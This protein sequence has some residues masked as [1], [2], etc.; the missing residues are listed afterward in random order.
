V[1]DWEEYV[2]RRLSI[3]SLP[4]EREMRIVR[5]LGAQLED[6]YREALAR[7]ASDS[8]AEAQ[9]E[10]QILDWDRL[11]LDLWR[12][13]R[14]R[15]ANP[16][17]RWSRKLEERAR[18]ARVGGSMLADLVADTRFAIR[19]LAKNPGFAAVA[20]VTLAIGIGA[21]SA[22][23]SVI[24]GVLL[25]P[26][27][28][29]SPERLVRVHET[30][31]QYGRFSVAP[32][33]FLDWRRESQA[34]ERIAAFSAGSGTLVDG[35]LVERVSS[36]EVSFD[37]FD[38]LGIA[39]LLGRG[40]SPEEDAPGRNGVVVV[41]HGAWQRH[42]GSD[43]GVLGRRVTLDGTAVTV[44]GVMPPDF[45]FPSR[46]NELWSPIALDPANAPR[47]A[48]YLGVIARL[49]PDA[50]VASARAEMETIA[51]RLADQFPVNAGES[52]EVTPLHEYIVGGSRASL[53]TLLTAVVLVT[54]I[55]CG[56][57]ANLL[58]GRAS[59]R[60]RE[61]ALRAALGAGRGRLARQMLAE[62]A[63]LALGGGAL[64]L[65]FAYA[66]LDPL[67][68]LSA[69]TIPRVEEIALDGGVLA[70][71]LGLS[72]VT[73]LGFALAPAW[74]SSRARPV[75]ALR[76][77]SR[78]SLSPGSRRARSALVAVEVALSLVL[79]VG[80]SLL[81]RSFRGLASVD[82][83][84][85]PENVLTL[86][87][88]LPPGDYPED[89]HLVHFYDQLLERL[90]SLPRVEAAGMVQSLPIEGDYFLSFTIEGRPDPPPGEEPSAN[91]R[92][93]SYGYFETVGVPIARGRTFDS[94]DGTRTPPVAVVDEAFVRRH[95]G[96]ED[97]LGR[98]IDVGNGSD[99]VYEIVGVAGDVRNDGLELAP[100]P[101]IYLPYPQDPFRT[102][103]VVLR[104]DS[105]P[106]RL[107]AD[108][109][110]V[111][112]ELDAMLPAYSVRALED[113]VDESLGER[114][115]SMLLLAL[116]AGTASFL[117]AVGLYGV[118]SYS[119]SRRTREM[120]LRLAVGASRSSLILTVMRQGMKPALAGIGIGISASL[121]LAGAL[122]TLLF[123]VTP[124]DPASYAATVLLLLLVAAFACYIPARRASGIDPLAALREE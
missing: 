47:G 82:P 69:G 113:V 25:R 68:R 43:P 111:V 50:S 98:R 24:D 120:G 105:D 2:R 7:G 1:R 74:G 62:G 80:A 28:Y 115:F 23:F 110:D 58:L 59:A 42:F 51:K 27:P 123:G 117:A 45:H 17:S 96:A 57:V 78:G 85:R 107:A 90:R 92:I 101:S 122:E 8:E 46:E 33:N 63:I 77:A 76:E 16:V 81:L 66:A 36:A 20:I 103:S 79:L 53:L 41:S 14:S 48:H 86:K 31:P 121:L 65:L 108:A 64:G 73:G 112:R 60:G 67:R 97:P 116:F 6:F 106:L 49:K 102:M 40:F 38:L 91:Y 39:P 88:S 3:P 95:F 61:I 55:S 15:A 52:A 100:H 93:A 4:P 72:V 44:V 89:H 94:R 32:A 54:L 30:T 56:N 11:A 99:A 9:A 114:R 83:G 119:V 18:G 5:E 29:S 21:T 13:D 10:R 12:A 84:F 75:E 109:R 34:F 70:F 124:F 19:E 118:V 22:I 104:T 26:L 35:D 71:T 87:I 37:L